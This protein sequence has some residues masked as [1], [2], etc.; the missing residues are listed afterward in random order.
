MHM[1]VLYNNIFLHR[2]V[3]TRHNI[4]LDN[5]HIFYVVSLNLVQF[6]LSH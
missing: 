6:L 1:H 5:K 3:L 4:E 2:V